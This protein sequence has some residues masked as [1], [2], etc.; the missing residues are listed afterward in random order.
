MDTHTRLQQLLRERGWTEYKLS[1]SAAWHSPLSVI[2]S[3]GTPF[4]LLRLLRRYVE[5][6]ASLCH[7]SSQTPNG[8]TDSGYKRGVRCLDLP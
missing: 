3:E 8:G 1:K 7:S 5:V 6:L 2:F 4:H